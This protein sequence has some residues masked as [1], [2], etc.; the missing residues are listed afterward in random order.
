MVLHNDIQRFLAGL[1]CSKGTYIIPAFLYICNNRACE[2]SI[3]YLD[4][5]NLAKPCQ[6]SSIDQLIIHKYFGRVVFLTSLVI[7]NKRMSYSANVE[8]KML[9]RAC[10]NRLVPQFQVN[11]HVLN[12]KNDP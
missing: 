2:N 7:L 1:G 5:I 11:E 9:I 6:S 4:V 10:T 3:S 12:I 8:F